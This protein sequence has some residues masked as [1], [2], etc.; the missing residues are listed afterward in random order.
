LPDILPATQVGMLFVVDDP[1]TALIL[2]FV[3]DTETDGF[4]SNEYR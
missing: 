1:V 3:V 4:S 2:R